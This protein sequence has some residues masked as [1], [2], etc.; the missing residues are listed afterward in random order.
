VLYRDEFVPSRRW[1]QQRP[2]VRRLTFLTRRNSHRRTTPEQEGG[3]TWRVA[4]YAR[5]APGRAGVGRLDGRV[6]AA[7]DNAAMEP[8]YW[9]LQMNVLDQRRWSR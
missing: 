6:A 9:I 2:S 1:K 5:E 4:I 8:F 3:V 7:G